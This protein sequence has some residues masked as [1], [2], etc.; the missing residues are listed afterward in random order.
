MDNVKVSVIVTVYNL[1]MYIRQCIDSIVNQTLEDIE[2][3]CVDD[4]S[5]DKSLEILKEYENNDSR[6]RVVTQENAGA[7]AARNKGMSLASGKYLSFLDGDDFFEPDM[8]EKAYKLAEADEA[9][10][11][12]YKSNQYHTESET[13]TFPSWVVR[14]AELP[15]YHPFSFRQVTTNVFK[16]F[17]GWAWD[18]LY[19]KEFIDK[20]NLKFQEQRTSND[21]YFVFAALVLAKRISVV[22]EILAHQR[23]D[24]RD[25]LSK[26][27]ENS[28][29]CFYDA[30]TAIKS[31]LIKE[32]Y[33]RELEKDFINYSLHA[34]LWNYD[35]LAEPTKSILA[36]KLNSE[37]FDELGISDKDEKYFYNN[38]EYKKYKTLRMIKDNEQ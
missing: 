1:E 13:Y 10:F 30:L 18:K 27:R 5:T 2:I 38:N 23:R 8:L 20:Y 25:S 34:C 19:R 12:V 15:P 22:P 36:D 4:G 26:T 7:G 33:Y 31:T 9:D 24:S 37:W 28:W 14:E 29:Q 11:V 21:M 35:T 17:V 32:G 6:I 3:I 16:V